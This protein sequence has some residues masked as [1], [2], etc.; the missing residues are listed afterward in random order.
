MKPNDL[1]TAIVIGGVLIVLGLDP[2]LVDRLKDGVQDVSDSFYS[3]FPIRV[4]HQTD[5]QKLPRPLWLAVPG[6]ALIL[7]SLF[8]Y[9]SS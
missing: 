1:A 2:G 3:R 4:L 7:L 6:P 8:A 5:Y 9:I